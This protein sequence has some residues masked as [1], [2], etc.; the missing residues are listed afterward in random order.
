MQGWCAVSEHMFGLYRGHLSQRLVRAIEKR[1]PYVAV[2]NHTEPRGEKRGWFAGPNRGNP[3]DR[4]MAA[5]VLSYARSV[6]K[7]AD[8]EKLGGES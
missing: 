7:G 6:A 3:F 1:F 2:V 5:A 4:D 8:A